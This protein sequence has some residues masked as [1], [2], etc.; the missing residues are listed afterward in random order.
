[1]APPPSPHRPLATLCSGGLAGRVLVS[2]AV[3]PTNASALREWAQLIHSR[4]ETIAENAMIAATAT[5]HRLTVIARN[6]RDF[7]ELGVELYNR[8]N[9]G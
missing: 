8:F 7:A 3:L 9:T 5:V 4:S 6:V 2:W 1:M